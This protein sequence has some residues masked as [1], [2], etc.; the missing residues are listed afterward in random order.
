MLDYDPTAMGL[1]GQSYHSLAPDTLDLADRMAL[2]VN[3]LTN[4]WYP[5]E[6]WGQGFLTDIS[7]HRCVP[8]YPTEVYR[9]PGFLPDRIRQPAEPAGRSR[10]AQHP[11]LFVG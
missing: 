10:G 11:A 3:A 1:D 6:R 2:A 7:H 8:Q 4:V 5:A 9:S